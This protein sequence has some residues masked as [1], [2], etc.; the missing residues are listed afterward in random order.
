MASHPISILGSG[1]PMLANG[2]R[3]HMEGATSAHCSPMKTEHHLHSVVYVWPLL[4][5]YI[6]FCALLS[7]PLVQIILLS[8]LLLYAWFNN[9]LPQLLPS[10]TTLPPVES[11]LSLSSAS[12]ALGSP[13]LVLGNGH[14]LTLLPFSLFHLPLRACR[15]LSAMLYFTVVLVSW[16]FTDQDI[17]RLPK[18]LTEHF[19]SASVYRQTFSKSFPRHSGCYSSYVSGVYSMKWY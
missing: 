4:S 7:D 18:C 14:C 16:S 11:G 19:M 5:S 8:V 9:L 1:E 3:S 12:L 17:H 13:S 2:V 15:C 10:H 6:D